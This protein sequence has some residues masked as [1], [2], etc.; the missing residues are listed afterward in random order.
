MVVVCL[1]FYAIGGFWFVIV[2]V[3]VDFLF[4]VFFCS[5]F[6]V[7]AARDYKSPDQP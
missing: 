2:F 7:I 4:I 5:F 1:L 6:Y 3:F